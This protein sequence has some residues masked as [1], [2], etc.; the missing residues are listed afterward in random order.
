MESKTFLVA[1]HEDPGVKHKPRDDKEVPHPAA[2]SD[3]VS[4]RVHV[5]GHARLAALELTT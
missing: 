3:S 5:R 1:E 4:L 2:V